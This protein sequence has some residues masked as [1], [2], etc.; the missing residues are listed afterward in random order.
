MADNMHQLVQLRWLALGGQLVTILIVNIGFDIPLPLTEMLGLVAALALANLATLWLMPRHRVNSAEIALALLFDMAVLAGQLYLS[1]GT[2]N[3]FSLLFLVQ[4]VLGAILLG[5]TGVWLLAVVAV[6]SYAGLSLKHLPLRFA[7]RLQGEVAD[8]YT[9]GNWLGF[10]LAT[11]LLI[12]FIG[13]ISRNLRARDANVLELRRRAAEEDGIVRMG[14]FASGA[15][16]E[17]GTPLATLSVILGDWQRM[18]AIARNKTLSE[19]LAEMRSEVERCKSIVSDILHLAGEP[20]GEEMASI[21]AAEALS[22]IAED[23]RRTH[24]QVDL[25]LNVEPAG[26]ACIIAEPALRQAILSL[27]DNAAEASPTVIL[28]AR[29]DATKLTISV[30]DFGGGFRPEQ[31]E[32]IGKPMRSTKGHGHGLGLFLGTNVAR[33]LGGRLA[34]TNLAQGAE[35]AIELPLLSSSSHLDRHA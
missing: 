19:E 13:R 17:L 32:A 30:R 10:A 15:A 12:L 11:V 25:A 34:A 28:S 31:L 2:N 18:P 22:E 23:W 35:V 26:E 27:L 4:V 24:V 16:H 8:L 21:K 9:L 20:R 1:G 3:P 29:A 6:L 7:P 14:L 5:N 33:R